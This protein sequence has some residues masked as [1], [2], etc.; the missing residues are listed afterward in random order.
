MEKRQLH[1]FLVVA[2]CGV[3]LAGTGLSQEDASQRSGGRVPKDSGAQSAV[4]VK[5][6]TVQSRRI[7]ARAES[8]GFLEP[9][10]RVTVSARVPGE[11]LGQHIE[12]SDLVRVGD[13]LF[14]IDDALRVIERDQARA[15]A[16]QAGSRYELADAKWKRVQKLEAT[17]SSAEIEKVEART[18]RSAAL[19]RQTEAKALLRRAALTLERTSI[20]SPLDGVV[21]EVLIRKGEYA[22]VGQ[23]V[24][25]IIEVGRLKLATEVSD[26]EVI[27]LRAGQPCTLSTPLYPLETFQ[28]RVIRVYPEARSGSHKFG[29]EVEIP[30]PEGRLKPGFFMQ[31]TFSRTRGDPLDPMLVIP[32]VAVEHKSGEQFCFVVDPGDSTSRTSTLFRV[33]RTVVVAL[34]IPTEPENLR[35]VSG[36]K[37]GDRVVIKGSRYLS[38]GAMVRID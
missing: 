32:A 31:A 37:M 30:N 16:E 13:L 18:G 7:E 19:A 2:A 14:K 21:S 24:A 8:F 27:W 3:A 12:I 25:Q 26:R 34:P 38:D 28:G 5:V 15:V 36:L 10:L 35:V 4:S 22:Q 9:F 20:L 6:I 1:F 33:R 17:D 23:P 29:I 11:V